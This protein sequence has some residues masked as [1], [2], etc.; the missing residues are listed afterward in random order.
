[1]KKNTATRQALGRLGASVAFRI[2]IVLM[3]LYI[4]Y[5]C[6]ASFSDRVVTD[7]VT[8]GEARTT[9]SGE[10]V[11]FRDETVLTVAGGSAL[12]SYPNENGAKVNTRSV[13]SQL[14]PMAGDAAVLAQHQRTLTAL[15][16]QI[17]LADRYGSASELLSVLPSLRT[18]ARD[19]L[20][21]VTALVSDGA[22]MRE[23][24][25]HTDAFLLLLHRMQALTGEGLSMSATVDSLRAERNALLGAA[26]Y[27]S[28]TLTLAD[29]SSDATGGYFYHA[30]SVDG[31]EN[32]FRA[33][34]L[35]GLTVSQLE[36]LRASQ[37]T[38]YGTGVTVVGKL[39]QGYEWSIVLPLDSASAS[40]LEVGEIYPVTFT[41]ENATTIDMTLVQVVT[42][43]TSPTVLAV[44]QSTVTPSGFTYPRFARVSLTLDTRRGYRIPETALVGQDGENGE[45]GVYILDGGRVS[46]R[47]VRILFRGEGYVI[48]YTPTT[49]ERESEQDSTYHYDRYVALRDVV[50]TEG[51][52]LYDGKYID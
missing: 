10:A 2:F 35:D 5:H 41:D 48:V 24:E 18:Q 14:Y 36:S 45:N 26:L 27:H 9:L 40:Q 3:I 17:A 22:P 4:L 15:D 30:S 25:E 16:R 32:V 21:S 50:I 49:E 33:S 38:V 52:N 19:E 1:M 11:L 29:V 7:V 34:Q 6:V 42:D 13:L 46:Y 51:D 39:V 31:Y 23:I 44:L 43:P 8:D 20:L 47:D 12:C 28:R 37:P